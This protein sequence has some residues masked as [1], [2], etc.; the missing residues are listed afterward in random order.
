MV[1]DILMQESSFVGCVRV[2]LEE[3][4]VGI[5]RVVRLKGLPGVGGIEKKMRASGTSP[6]GRRL[7]IQR[8]E[9]CV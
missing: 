4:P 8:V 1:L 2:I 9:G 3:H 7:R 6:L 5:M